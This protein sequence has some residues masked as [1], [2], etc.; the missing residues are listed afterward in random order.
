MSISTDGRWCAASKVNSFVISVDK[1]PSAAQR[2]LKAGLNNPAFK[3]KSKGN[4]MITIL[5]QL[6]SS[7]GQT[8]LGFLVGRFGLSFSSL[9]LFHSFSGVCYSLTD[10]QELCV[11]FLLR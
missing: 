8:I 10:I 5:W 6:L 3:K 1:H 11:V 4:A 7:L 2:A 9:R